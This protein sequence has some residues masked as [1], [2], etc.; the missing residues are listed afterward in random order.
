MGFKVQPTFYGAYGELVYF[1]NPGAA[2]QPNVPWQEVLLYGGPTVNRKGPDIDLAMHDFDGDGVPEIVATKFFT[3]PNVSN[4]GAIDIYGPPEGQT[5]ADVNA[6]NLARTN[7][8]SVGQGLP[9]GIKI[10]DLNGD[11]KKDVL[12]TN[13]QHDACN[14]PA[15]IP[16]RVYA[17]EAPAN[18]DLFGSAWT[19]RILKNNIRPQPNLPG[20]AQPGRLAPGIAIPFWPIKFME[21]LTKPHIVVGGDESGKVWVL[22]PQDSTDPDNWNYDSGVVFDINTYYGEYTTQT[23]LPAGHPAEGR[24]NGTIGGMAVRYTNNSDFG[25]AEFYIPAYEGRDIHVI[26]YQKPTPESEAYSCSPDVRYA[27][28]AP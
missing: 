25:A 20:T 23:R 9:F 15:G 10:V 5:W 22:A 28:P 19:T 2:I 14:R 8:I 17:M 16:G 11:G 21:N 26:S 1:K 6:G 24:T 18:G 13:H 7:N 4:A 27:C 3:G 12:A